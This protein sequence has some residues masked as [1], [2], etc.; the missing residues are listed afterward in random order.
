M[1]G[2][3]AVA[4]AVLRSRSSRQRST[5]AAMPV[6]HVTSSTCIA[7][8]RIVVACRAFQAMTGIITFNSSWPESAAASIAASHPI[9]WKHTWLT[10]SGTEGLTLPGMIDDPG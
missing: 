7:R 5:S 3:S 2:L 1:C 6:T 8:P 4:S 9:T 10:I